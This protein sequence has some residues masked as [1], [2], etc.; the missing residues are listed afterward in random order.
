MNG[1]GQIS[2]AVIAALQS[3]GVTAVAAYEGRA[4]RYDGPVAAVDVESA[5]ESAP[6][7]GNYLGQAAARRPGRSRNSTAG[8]WM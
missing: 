6:G 1:L 4:K 2:A 5:A 7:M 8:R 3:A